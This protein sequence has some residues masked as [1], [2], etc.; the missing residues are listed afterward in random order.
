MEDWAGGERKALPWK[1]GPLD[2][3]KTVK[4][5]EAGTKGWVIDSRTAD[6]VLPPNCPLPPSA[7]VASVC[8]AHVCVGR[9]GGL[10]VK[11]RE[12]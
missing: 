7:V 11:E 2:L 6:R 9:G 3:E 8:P 4:L 10:Q 5:W 1:T 12:G